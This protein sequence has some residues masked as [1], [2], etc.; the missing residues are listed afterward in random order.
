MNRTG[1]NLLFYSALVICLLLE[2]PGCVTPTEQ[3]PAGAQFSGK[4][5]GYL[6]EI[7]EIQAGSFETAEYLPAKIRFELKNQ[8]REKGLLSGQSE[9]EKRLSVSI[10]IEATYSGWEAGSESYNEL[11]SHVKV[12]DIQKN[13]MIAHTVISEFSAWGSVLSDFIEITHAKEI[14]CFLESVV[15]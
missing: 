11:I 2:C 5:K 12:T 6:Y 14:A 7:G 4:A 13:E 3:D 15:R 8:L 1:K 10:T 9:T